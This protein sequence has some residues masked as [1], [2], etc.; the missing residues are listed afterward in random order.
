MFPKTNYFI[1]WIEEYWNQLIDI[2][3]FSTYSE[4]KQHYQS[5]IKNEINLSA[6]SEIDGSFSV[7][8][9]FILLVVEKWLYRQ[10]NEYEKGAM[11]QYRNHF[12]ARTAGT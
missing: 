9:N 10:A 5:E 8:L 3:S 6:L 12:E 1:N 11:K 4:V 7:E 2:V